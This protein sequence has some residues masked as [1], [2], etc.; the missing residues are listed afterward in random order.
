MT[1]MHMNNPSLGFRSVLAACLGL[2]A[3]LSLAIGCQ[4]GQGMNIAKLPPDRAE[5]AGYY[6]PSQIEILPFTKPG[7]FDARGLPDGINAVVRPT[8][9]L[10]DPV[11]AYG[12]I[13]FELYSYVPTSALHKGEQL[14]VWTQTLNTPAD[15]RK[16]WDRV[17]QSY[18]FQLAWRQPLQ[19]N[20][21]YVLE[22]AYE[23]PAGTRLINDYEFEFAP[24]VPQIR[25]ELKNQPR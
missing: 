25:E 4:K 23:N 22:V 6:L 10:G 7:S 13:R 18:Q 21:R 15:Q 16:Y 20:K 24:N 11:K 14:M 17:T 1:G 12:T 3:C 19:P 8:D 2:L 5:M 9:V